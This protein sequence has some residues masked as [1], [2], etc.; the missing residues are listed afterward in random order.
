MSAGQE[1]ALTRGY[2]SKVVATAPVCYSR[3]YDGLLMI[4]EVRLIIPTN[5]TALKKIKYTSVPF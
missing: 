1:S 5:S 3:D 2:C 4:G